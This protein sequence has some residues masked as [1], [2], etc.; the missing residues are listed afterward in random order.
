M[1]VGNVVMTSADLRKLEDLVRRAGVA[2]RAGR[3]DEA[4]TLYLQA[5]ERAKGADAE[6]PARMA[7]ALHATASG[8]REMEDL[9]RAELAG[10][11]A[12]AFARRANSPIAV[13]NNLMFLS[14]LVED[15]NRFSEASH[16]AIQA[17]PLYARVLGADHREVKEI[18]STLSRLYRRHATS[19]RSPWTSKPPRVR[20]PH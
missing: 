7:K 8:L 3:R 13:A 15:L 11:R 14:S 9:A 4:R 2:R 20:K 18:R 17:L 19:E 12:L 5:W 10:A 16:Y 1:T 6:E